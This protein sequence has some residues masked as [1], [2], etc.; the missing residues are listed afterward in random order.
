MI[1]TFYIEKIERLLLDGSEDSLLLAALE[2]RFCLEQI[3]YDRLKNSLG[4]ISA[5]DLKSWQPSQIVNSLILEVGPGVADRMVVEVSDTPTETGV[6][7]GSLDDYASKEWHLLGT[8]SAIDPKKIGKLWNALSN[9]ALHMQVPSELYGDP[10]ERDF[11]AIRAK[12]V[13]TLLDLKAINSGNLFWGV[14]GSEVLFECICGR[15]NARKVNRL[16]QGH[17]VHCTNSEC[18][19]SYSFDMAGNSFNRR[20]FEIACPSCQS[21]SHYPLRAIE[22]M[23]FEEIKEFKCIACDAVNKVSLRPRLV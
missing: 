5:K 21:A 19:E 2:S 11:N 14:S 15:V 8:Q 1:Y 9:L 16:E 6:V 23:R 12:V 3:C 18:N 17:I 10:W 4:H 22:K 20:L 7:A 13:E